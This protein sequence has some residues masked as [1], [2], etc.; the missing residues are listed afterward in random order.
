MHLHLLLL[1]LGWVGAFMECQGS[2]QWSTARTALGQ[3]GVFIISHI[4]LVSRPT[5]QR[6]HG[7]L[8][9][10]LPKEDEPR[11]LYLDVL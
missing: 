7:L 2:L 9:T 1:M 11:P 5:S 10:G 4:A 3:L 8:S 6:E